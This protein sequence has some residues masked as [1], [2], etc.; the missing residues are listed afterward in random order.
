[1]V[2][3]NLASLKLHHS[4][5]CSNVYFSGKFGLNYLMQGKTIL[6][7]IIHKYFHIKVHKQLKIYRLWH[8][9]YGTKCSVW[10]QPKHCLPKDFLIKTHNTYF[11]QIKPPVIKKKCVKC[12]QNALFTI[13]SYSCGVTT[14]LLTLCL[15]HWFS[16]ILQRLWTG[17]SVWSARK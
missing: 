9:V 16:V 4:Y 17:I 10:N 2:A 6:V 3:V 1:M 15:S 13:K 7:N 8:T 11:N 14:L 12:R 5:L